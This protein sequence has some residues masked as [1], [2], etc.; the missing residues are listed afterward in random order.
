MPTINPTQSSQY[1]NHR[2]TQSPNV[3]QPL[4]GVLP[5]N[6]APPIARAA[7][8][9]PA[10]PQKDT[11]SRVFPLNNK[12]TQKK[13]STKR[14]TVQLA[15][16]V[17]P[18]VKAELQRVAV[19]EGLTVSSTG[20]ALLEKAL[21]RDLHTQHAALLQPV[22]EQAIRKSMRA[23]SNRLAFLLVRVAF[24]GEQTRNVVTNILDK[25]PGMTADK[26]NKIL[27]YSSKAAKKSITR[28]TPQLEII[29]TELEKVFANEREQ[30]PGNA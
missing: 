11:R 4:G 17:N 5:D 12:S 30:E 22:I 2:R 8:R 27:D 18:R 7:T 10:S 28:K 16:W 23:Y 1:S 13:S 15:L 14:R 6:P 21:V 9:Q 19:L 20:A 3:Q 26:R 25:Q 29:L 24:A